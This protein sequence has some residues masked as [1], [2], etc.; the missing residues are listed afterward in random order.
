MSRKG[1]GSIRV[2]L[3]NFLWLL[4]CVPGF[5]SFLLASLNVRRTQAN[6]LQRILRRNAGTEIGRRHHFDAIRSPADFRTVPLSEYE[7]YAPLIKRIKGGETSCLTAEAVDTLVPTSGSTQATKL[8]PYTRSLKREFLVGV[9]PWIA[10]L[11]FSCPSLLGGR[12]YWSISPANSCFNDSPTKVPI[13][14]ADDTEYLGVFQGLLS[15]TILAVPPELSRISDPEA[16]EY[17][18]LLFLIREP[19]LRLISVWHPSFLTLL[20]KS[21]GKHLSAIIGDLESGIINTNVKI[22]EK[23]RHSL[24]NYFESN[25]SRAKELRNVKIDHSDFPVRIWPSLR[26]ISCWTDGHSEPWASELAAYFPGVIIQGK[27][28]IATEGIVSFPL[29]REGQR[30][31]AMR[32]HFL[33]FVD[34]ENGCARNAWEVEQGKTYSV[35]IT[36]GGGL[37][38]YR[39]HDVVRITG[40]FNQVPCLTFISRDNMVSDLVGEKLNAEYV[41]DCIRSIEFQLGIKFSFAMLAPRTAGDA[42]G[43]VFY[44]QVPNSAQVDYPAI[45][46]ALEDMLGKNYHYQHARRIS[47]LQPVR[48]FRI[49]GDGTT[50]YRDY[51]LGKG[52]KAGD[53]KFTPLS[54][55]SGWSAILPGEFI[56]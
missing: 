42:P 24:A 23:L 5:I 14:F 28:L 6:V 16:F 36:T 17:L 29:G 51:L 3:A 26:V 18:T 25:T 21:V 33:E 11:Y 47:Q 45:A 8:I 31:C 39:L 7:D 53:I 35:V 20:I 34:T 41:S 37:Y 40:F 55:D 13:G 4:S 27:G 32:S 48:L 49:T 30:V 15:Q 46:S 43:Y 56:V 54:L 44:A 1:P 22:Q 19:N 50:A 52:M 38:R 12:H 2:Y 9:N 10:S